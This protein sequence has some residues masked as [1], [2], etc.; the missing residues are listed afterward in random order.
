MVPTKL[1]EPTKINLNINCYAGLSTIIVLIL[2]MDH[3][4]LL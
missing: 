3:H 4:G 2:H 1:V